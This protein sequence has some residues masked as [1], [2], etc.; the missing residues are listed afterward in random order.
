M[1]DI[2]Y[3][4]ALVNKNNRGKCQNKKM[5]WESI[6]KML[7]ETKRTKETVEEYQKMTKVERDNIKNIG[8]FV[9]GYCKDG[10]RNNES[11]ETRGIVALD[12]DNDP[13][14]ESVWAKAKLFKSLM[15]TTHS[16][17]SENP[18]LR[19]LIP[20]DRTMAP[21]EYSKVSK[22]LANHIGSGNFSI[23]D[24]TTY[25]FSRLMYLP[26]TC[27]DGEFIFKD[28][29]EAR[30]RPEAKVDTL[31][32]IYDRDLKSQEE[33]VRQKRGNIVQDPTAKT[34]YIG[35][36]C[37]TYNIHEA[38]E[39]FLAEEYEKGSKEDRYTYLKG[40]TGDGL[41]VFDDGLLAFSYQDTDLISGKGNCNSFDLVR[42]HLFGKLDSDEDIN[43]LPPNKLP[44]FKK[45]CEFV[46]NDE[47]ARLKLSVEEFGKIDSQNKSSGES[48]I[49]NKDYTNDGLLKEFNS[50]YGKDIKY[51]SDMEVY[52]VW[53]G[54]VWVITD[55]KAIHKKIINFIMEL[56]SELEK[57]LVTT[58]D[59]DTKSFWKIYS[60]L[61]NLTPVKVIKD[62]FNAVCDWISSKELDNNDNLINC[63]NGMLNLDTMELVHHNREMLCTKIL[64]I[65]YTPNAK[66]DNF[67]NSLEWIFTNADTR[68]ELQKAYGYSLTG[69][70][71]HEVLF[72]LW[73]KGLNGKS[74]ITKP[75]IDIFGDYFGSLGYKSLEP[76]KDN[77]AP[78]SD[79]A[80]LVNKRVVLTSESKSKFTIDDG[81]LKTISSGELLNARFMRQNEFVYK[82]KFKLW[83]PTNI[84]PYIYNTDFG[85]WR[86]LVIFPCVNTPS[87]DIKGFYDKYIKPDE[88]P[89]ILNWAIEGLKIL[90]EEGFKPTDEMKKATKDYRQDVNPVEKFISECCHL[91]KVE[92]IKTVELLCKYNEWVA[93]EGY[94]EMKVRNFRG[95]LIDLGFEVR[96][97][98][99]N[100][101]FVFGI[102]DVKV[103][104]GDELI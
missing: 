52:I 23:F 43:N 32:K 102:E 41:Q 93:G 63:K 31:I 79:F 95:R 60:R 82:P 11:V 88:L 26:S 35:A 103:N 9:C 22:A 71:I 57:Y 96:K 36:F 61:K 37:K 24:N 28:S 55:I 15:Y 59:E 76:K 67:I 16:H 73:G 42:Y 77:S 74:T 29:C 100:I 47:R 94:S 69:E 89:G 92:K 84:L 70:T 104:T 99:D 21:D 1:A 90:N 65:D 86:R 6:V 30:N 101:S 54:S 14:V 75:L 83:I 46:A 33:E 17:T 25:Q 48:Y 44:S 56:S 58:A 51:I 80:K 7:K 62:N 8:G 98:N 66:C 18:R 97:A 12:L 50:S 13:N 10:I 20:T 53:N 64:N 72:I 38:I 39:T 2:T 81:M 40:H 87:K 27:K 4:V 68:K 78:S 19:I 49:R 85:F 5:T 34:G 91:D 45:M 3:D